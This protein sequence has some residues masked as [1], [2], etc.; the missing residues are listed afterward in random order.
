MVNAS[1]GQKKRHPATL[2][3]KRTL[4]LDSI[5]LGIDGIEELLSRNVFLLIGIQYFLISDLQKSL[6]ASAPFVGYM[7]SLLYTSALARSRFKK[8]SLLA[9]P[10]LISSIGIAV[11]AFTASG[12]AF[13]IAA[14]S[15]GSDQINTCEGGIGEPAFSASRA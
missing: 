13:R 1:D 7:A 14:S 6:L 9:L 8:S 4:I 10:T 11:S 2:R 3:Q 12:L 5:R 15:S